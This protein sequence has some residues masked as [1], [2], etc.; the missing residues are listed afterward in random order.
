MD[1][2]IQSIKSAVHRWEGEA[3]RVGEELKQLESTTK[4]EGLSCVEWYI[5]VSGSTME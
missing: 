3:N 2:E 5:V 1:G 4:E